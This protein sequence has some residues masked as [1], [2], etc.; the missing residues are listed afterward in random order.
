MSIYRDYLGTY[1]SLSAK[2]IDSNTGNEL[3]VLS[4]ITESPFAGNNLVIVPVNE[5]LTE[6]APQPNPAGQKMMYEEIKDFNNQLSII[7]TDVLIK[8]VLSRNDC[9][10]EF[11]LKSKSDRVISES[12]EVVK[13][14]EVYNPET[15]EFE[16]SYTH[17]V[18]VY[19]SE[20]RAVEVLHNL[21]DNHCV[22][23]RIEV[24]LDF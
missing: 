3:V 6:T 13:I 10:E 22:I 16:P 11:L 20:D 8:E 24:K 18:N 23:K 12:Y 4:P 7:P 14:G 21:S 15:D 19:D 17:I 5:F 1:F 2:G 9:P